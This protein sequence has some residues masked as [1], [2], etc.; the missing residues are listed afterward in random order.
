MGVIAMRRSTKRRRWIFIAALV[1]L[2][3]ALVLLVA[4]GAWTQFRVASWQSKAPRTPFGVVER[5]GFRVAREDGG[6]LATWSDEETVTELVSLIPWTDRGLGYAFNCTQGSPF[7][8]IFITESD[9]LLDVLLAADSCPTSEPAWRDHQVGWTTPEL[10]TRVGELLAEEPAVVE[11][12]GRSDV[13]WMDVS[14][15]SWNRWK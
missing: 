12:A 8:L 7:H 11:Y 9:E 14:G 1:A 6:K 2:V 5:V 15:R 3:T 10:L 4:S 13:P